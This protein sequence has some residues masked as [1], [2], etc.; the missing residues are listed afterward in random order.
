MTLSWTLKVLEPLGSLFGSKTYN[1]DG[2][3][4]VQGE[5]ERMVMGGMAAYWFNDGVS[6]IP[7]MPLQ[8]G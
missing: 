2:L 5:T 8:P 7:A 4:D 1:Q 3:L 6:R